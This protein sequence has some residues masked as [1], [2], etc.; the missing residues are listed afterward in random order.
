MALNQLLL[1]ARET[2]TGKAE[3]GKA[4]R[5]KD[6]R[7]GFRHRRETAK[8]PGDDFESALGRV[9]KEEKERVAS[10]AGQRRVGE[11]YQRIG[12]RGPGRIV[13]SKTD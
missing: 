12:N 3:T 7:G 8:S 6:E 10:K 9:A 4:E 5:E 1:A 13:Q 11:K 2:E